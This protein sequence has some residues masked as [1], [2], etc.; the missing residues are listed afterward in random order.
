MD[1]IYLRNLQVS[2]IVGKDAWE[3]DNKLQPLVLNIRVERDVKLAGKY[4]NIKETISYG[5]MCKDVMNLIDSRKSGFMNISSLSLNIQTLALDKGWA[6]DVLHVTITSP[7][8]SL[9]AEGGLELRCIYV[10]E[11]TAGM[12]FLVKDLKTACIIGVNAHER[13]RKQMVVIELKIEVPL[14]VAEDALGGRDLMFDHYRGVFRIPGQI[15]KS[16]EDYVLG[17]SL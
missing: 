17:V 14:G 7:K 9:R 8:A 6:A 13:Q 3:R 2:A 10:G 12:A 5:Q 4:D 15:H 11:A 16:V 1:T